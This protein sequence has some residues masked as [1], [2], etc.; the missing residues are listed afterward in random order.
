MEKAVNS[1]AKDSLVDVILIATMLPGP[2]QRYKSYICF[3][4]SCPGM[5]GH[6][7]VTKIDV[8]FAILYCDVL[9]VSKYF[10][11]IIMNH[12]VQQSRACYTLLEISIILHNL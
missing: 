5:P 10:W 12:P 7:K 6:G 2:G 8:L 1:D 11:S 4:L 3:L 9:R